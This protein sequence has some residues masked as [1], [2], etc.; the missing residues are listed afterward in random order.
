MHDSDEE[1]RNS[2]SQILGK[3]GAEAVPIIMELL[4][5]TDPQSKASAANAFKYFKDPKAKEELL[6]VR[7]KNSGWMASQKNLEVARSIDKALMN[8]N[9]KG[10]E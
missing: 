6:K 7:S 3:V 1:V 9:S 4:T 2:C 8:M 5:S 10:N